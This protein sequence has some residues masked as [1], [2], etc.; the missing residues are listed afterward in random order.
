MKWLASGEDGW[1]GGAERLKTKG[2]ERQ[3]EGRR[4]EKEREERGVRREDLAVALEVGWRQ[5]EG[6]REGR[7]ETERMGGRTG[8]KK[9][10]RLLARRAR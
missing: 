2:K 3:T 5:R 6:V 10:E 7:G 4:E 1:E 8:R 9:V